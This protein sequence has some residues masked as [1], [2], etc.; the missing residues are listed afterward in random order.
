MTSDPNRVRTS[1]PLAKHAVGLSEELFRQGYS[2]ERV[3]HHLQLLAQ[4]S[5][6]LESQGLG[7]HDLSEE[8]VAQFLGARRAEGYSRTPPLS[9]ALE[10]L[11]LVPA[12]EI[13][14]AVPA[15]L[16]PLEAMVERFGR[17]LLAER[18]LATGTIRGY[19]GIARLF[20]SR[21]QGPGGALDLSSVSAQAVTAFVVSE[22]RRR[23][24]ASAQ[25]SVTALRSL[26]RFL[27]LEGCI[28]QRLG[29]A[30]P[31]V[32]VPKGFLPRGLA[33]EVVEA[34]L[35]SC[36][37]S[38]K[39]GKRDLAVLTALSRLGLRAG[40]VAGLGLDELD[41]AHGEVV[42][43]G[44]GRRTE[45]LP[46]P[47]DVGEALAAYL[48]SGRPKVECR[49]VFLRVHAPIGPM[50]A[51]NV[52]A[53]VRYACQRAGVPEVGPHRLRHSAATAMLRAGASLAEVG[54]VLRESADATTAIYAKVDRVALRALAQPWPG[55]LS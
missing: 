9:W 29:D 28:A 11:S 3:T 16:T 55:A 22:R 37:T 6:W 30:V 41:W 38:T 18:G 34:L 25:V 27:F 48:S 7:E 52:G 47:V 5:R 54:Q 8:R 2:P 13:A 10:L 44:K 31:A 42:V 36:D 26:L 43:R 4:L 51:S 40:E 19:L 15:P 32:S 12:L 50:T 53:I 46:L 23:S 1:G 20:L 21:W 17:Y 45:R 49:A 35:A 39:V 24:T 14:T 33:D